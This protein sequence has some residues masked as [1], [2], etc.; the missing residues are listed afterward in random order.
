MLGKKQIRKNIDWLLKNASAPV[1]YLT[2]HF[3]LNSKKGS[4]KLRNLWKEVEHDEEVVDIFSKQ[5]PDGSWCAGGAWSQPP[6]YIPKGGCTPVSPKYVT[7]AWILWLLGDLGFDIGDKRIQK[8]C[9]YVFSFQYKNGYISEERL[10]KYNMH[11]NELP[12]MPCR[13]SIVLVGLNKVG[14]A[15]DP[16]AKKS[17]DLLV[18]WQNG[19]GGWVLQKH[20]EEQNWD[21]SCPWS[22]FHATYALYAAQRKQYRKNVLRGLKFLLGHLSQKQ[23]EEIKKF[24][25]HGHSMVHELLMFSEFG[26]SLDK[27]PLSIIVDWLM[28]MYDEE[29]GCF[30]YAGKPI[31]QYR[32]RK[33]DMDARVAKYRLHHLIETDWFTYYITRIMQNLV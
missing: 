15:A 30:V 24:F 20:R 4:L 32:R 21:R 22:T 23:P 10:D 25:Y 1:Q 33:D 31:A 28:E 14:A 11:V 13:F 12:S 29:N 17:Y 16:Q 8:A 27:Q 6:S 7:T 18:R 26:F 9:D 3:L 2:H 19:D 5:R